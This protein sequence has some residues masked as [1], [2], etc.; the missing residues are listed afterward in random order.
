MKTSFFFFFGG[1]AGLA[2]I[3]IYRHIEI[4]EHS[5]GGTLAALA[6]Y[7]PFRSIDPASGHDHDSK[8]RKR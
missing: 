1:G 5:R 2:Y 4:V 3:Y 8:S 7:D 6:D